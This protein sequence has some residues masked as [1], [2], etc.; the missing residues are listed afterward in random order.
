MTLWKDYFKK[1]TINDLNG[2]FHSIWKKLAP[3]TWD[4]FAHRLSLGALR[5]AG[6]ATS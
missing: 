4:S 6:F 5:N 3:Y 1:K 2:T